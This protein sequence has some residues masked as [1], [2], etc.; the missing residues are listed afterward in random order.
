VKTVPTITTKEKKERVVTK[1]E[2]KAKKKRTLAESYEEVM[3]LGELGEEMEDYTESVN[4]YFDAKTIY[5]YKLEPRIALTETFFKR[6]KAGKDYYCLRTAR[7]LTYAYMYINDATSP[8]LVKQLDA[9]QS[10]LSKIY[11]VK[12]STLLYDS[13][14]QNSFIHSLNIVAL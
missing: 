12:D 14:I 11:T 5:P 6:C 1:V 3:I 10:N 8:E 7:E 2:K 4:R 13:F 9:L